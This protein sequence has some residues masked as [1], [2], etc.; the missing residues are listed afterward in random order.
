MYNSSACCEYKERDLLLVLDW[1]Y[2]FEYPEERNRGLDFR[3]DLFCYG[4]F[5]LSLKK[6]DKVAVIIS[7]H[8][9][10]GKDPF[11]IYDLEKKRRLN[12]F[13]NLPQQDNFS[14][15]FELY[16]DKLRLTLL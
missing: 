15:I 2:S 16:P 3:E 4:I 1:Y 9:P 6:G 14:K 11:E 5:K 10:A 7:T 13:S 12:L 8:E